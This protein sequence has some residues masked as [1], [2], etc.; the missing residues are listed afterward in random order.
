MNFYRKLKEF[1]PSMYD[2]LR[3]SVSTKDPLSSHG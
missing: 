1:E 3:T 2:R